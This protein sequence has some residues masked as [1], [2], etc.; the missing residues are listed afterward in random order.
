MWG[1]VVESFLMYIKAYQ[2]S[3]LIIFYLLKEA[4][5]H[6][7]Q[8]AAGTLLSVCTLNVDVVSEVKSD[9]ESGLYRNYVLAGQK[10]R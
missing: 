4:Y 8:P 10:R 5:C 7:L 2:Y 1:G 9:S 6:Y 3:H